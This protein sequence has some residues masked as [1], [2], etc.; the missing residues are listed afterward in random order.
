M[1]LSYC[2]SDSE[3]VPV[4]PIIILITFAIILVY[5]P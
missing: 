5:M 4:S 1:L 2:L 3:M